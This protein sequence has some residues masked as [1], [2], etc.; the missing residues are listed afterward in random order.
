MKS[1]ALISAGILLIGLP[2]CANQN[3]NAMG[4][5]CANVVSAHWISYK[6]DIAAFKVMSE[7]LFTS[8]T[9]EGGVVHFAPEVNAIMSKHFMLPATNKT[10]VKALQSVGGDDELLNINLIDES[11]L[12]S[13]KDMEISSGKPGTYL[14]YLGVRT[15]SGE[16]EVKCS[17]I[18]KK[19]VS[20][21]SGPVHQVFGT[22]DC[23][24][25]PPKNTMADL[26][27]KYCNQ[28]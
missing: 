24:T 25:T 15:I 9:H 1:I 2:G 26:V 18:N 22:L 27:K 12:A 11:Q 14:K 6:K 7:T 10:L 23:Q 19:I 21:V 3:T 4:E 5:V 28:G 13:L 20:I 8:G 16:L 17:N